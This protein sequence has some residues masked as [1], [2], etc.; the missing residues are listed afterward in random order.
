MLE[1]EL[2][3]SLDVKSLFT[4]VSIEEAIEIAFKELYSSDEVPETQRS[5]MRVAVAKFHSKSD[6]MCYSQLDG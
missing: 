5:A 3:L 6:K 1:I 4:N 2:M